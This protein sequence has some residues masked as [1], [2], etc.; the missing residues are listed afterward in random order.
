MKTNMKLA[1]IGGGISYG[2][3]TLSP[4]FATT[5]SISRGTWHSKATSRTFTSSKEEEWK[6]TPRSQV[7]ISFLGSSRALDIIFSLGTEVHNYKFLGPRA[8]L[9]GRHTYLQKL[10]E[11]MTDLVTLVAN[12]DS[13]ITSTWIITMTMKAW[14]KKKSP[15]LA[16]KNI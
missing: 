5:N 7:F 16:K 6:R 12:G 14:V 3:K 11:K 10:P 15:T 13:L 9:K 8:R 1:Y 2:T 4:I